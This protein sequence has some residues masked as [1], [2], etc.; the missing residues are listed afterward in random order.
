MFA[1]EKPIDTLDKDILGRAAFAA[2]LGNAIL[3]YKA[4]DSVV[5]SLYGSWGSGKTSL[6]HM[7]LD[8]IKNQSGTLS[9]DE[10]PIVVQFNPWLYSDQNQ[11]VTQ[12]F[13]DMSVALQHKDTAKELQKIGEKLGVYAAFFRPLTLIPEPMVSTMATTLTSIFGMFGKGAKQAASAKK[14]GLNEIRQ[15]L[16]SLPSKQK[17]KL[18]ITIDDI[19]RLTNIEIRQVFQMVKSLGDFPNTFYLLA[20]DRNV[21]VEALKE[22][23]KGDGHEYLE[24][25]VQIPFELPKATPS[26]LEKLFFSKLDEVV[27]TIPEDYWDNNY[28]NHIYHA[29]LKHLFGNIRD[30]SRFMNSY[31]FGYAFVGNEVNVIDFIAITAIQIFEYEVYEGIRSNKSLF[32]SIHRY[33]NSIDESADK[34]KNSAQF[35][36]ILERSKKLSTEQMEAFLS[37]LFPQIAYIN[38]NYG[39]DSANK[40][41]KGYRICSPDV[42]DTYFQLAIPNDQLSRNEIKSILSAAS[43]AET[44]ELILNDLIERGKLVQFLERMEDYTSADIPEENIGTIVSVLMDTG[45][46]FPDVSEG[47]FDLGTP[48]R[49]QRILYQLSQRYKSHEARFNLYKKAMTSASHSLYIAVQTVGILEQE[50][51]IRSSNPAQPETSRTVNA[52]QLKELE[53][54][55]GQK[56]QGWAD[57]G[58]LLSHSHLDEIL[59]SW[60]YF[61]NEETV[62]KY[63]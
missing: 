47:M 10:T 5:A 4:K 53:E 11:L 20:F 57:S 8:H 35:S 32:T 21:V 3:A 23:Q 18:I 63:A 51:G 16:D 22:V 49:V 58:K 55:V 7:M 62:L 60:K 27:E 31:R 1:P 36:E 37:Q 12:F 39:S 19:D 33:R 2:S 15:E 48:M 44:F 38:T 13:R 17:R 34:E 14:K 41:R 52:A 24:K 26:D 56:I 42:F 46:K 30:I 43:K 50:H 61:C 59:Y 29:G 6:V 54:L 25:I 45:D 28:W 9:N 40:W